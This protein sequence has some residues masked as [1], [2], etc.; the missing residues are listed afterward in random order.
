MSIRNYTSQVAVSRS[1]ENIERR[2]V[3]AGA[4]NIVRAYDEKRQIAGMVFTL[5]AGPHGELPVELPARVEQVEA[6]MRSRMRRVPNPDILR[7]QAARTAWKNLSEW[8]DIQIL[9]IDLQ[10]VEALEV[11]LPYLHDPKRKKNFYALVKESGF[12]M[13]PGGDA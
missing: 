4:R 8:V 6:L 11:F 5:P 3:G 9:L 2:L 10:Q 12:K 13:L 1:L 7:E